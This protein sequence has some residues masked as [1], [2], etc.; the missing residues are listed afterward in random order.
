MNDK[1]TLFI[2]IIMA[3]PPL[4]LISIGGIIISTTQENTMLDNDIA[5]IKNTLNYQS[6]GSEFLNEIGTKCN[7]TKYPII[8]KERLIK[9]T[10]DEYTIMHTQMTTPNPHTP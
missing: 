4:I 2:I 6:N 5:N 7:T 10:N 8:C 1:E 3:I 9:N